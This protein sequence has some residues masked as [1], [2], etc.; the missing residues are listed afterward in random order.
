MIGMI[1][2]LLDPILDKEESGKILIYLAKLEHIAIF[3]ELLESMY[4]KE[5]KRIDIGNYTTATGNKKIRLREL[6]N[7][8]IFT[9]VQ[10]GGVGLDLEEL[11]A[12]FSLVPYSSSITAS[13][14]IGR[15]RYIEGRELLYYDF[16]DKGFRAMDRQRFQ[17]MKILEVKS[18][19]DIRKKNISY[20]NVL[21]YLRE[22]F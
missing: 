7:R 12:V 11:I 13:Q 15:L 10:S 20:E 22:M 19:S 14:M 6:K 21:E 1:K 8:V 2:M 17:R 4:E 5:H 9:T 18:N 3:K 16:V